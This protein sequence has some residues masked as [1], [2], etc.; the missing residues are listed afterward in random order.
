[1]ALTKIGSIGINTGIAF[2]GVTT[3]ATLNASDNVLSVG[4]TVNFVSDVS[5]GGTVSIAG[6]LTYEDVTNVDAVGL[7]TARDGIKV[8]S[9]ITLST[10]GDIFATGVTTATTFSGAFSGSGANITALNASN[11]ASGTVPSARLGSGTASSSTFLAGDSTFKTVSGTTINNNADNKVITGSGTANTLNAEG[12]VYIDAEGDLGLGISDITPTA[13]T[14]NGA[15]LQL[16]QGQS[17]SYG[18]QLKMTTASGGYAAGDG[19]YIAHWGGNNGTYIYNKENAALYFGTNA[20]ERFRIGDSSNGGNVTVTDGDLVF[21]SAGH[22][23]D[24]S[25]ASGSAAGSASALLDD[26]EEGTYDGT[27]SVT[28]GTLVMDTSHNQLSY[29]KIGRQVTITG[30]VQVS[31]V[32]GLSGYMTMNL[33]F[34]VGASSEYDHGGAGSIFMYNAGGVANAVLGRWVVWTDGGLSLIYFTYGD[35]QSSVLGAYVTAGTEVR[36]TFTYFAS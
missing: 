21:G 16:H 15:T 10:D 7:I 14:Y 19:F 2:A 28:S 30:R 6:T 35:G 22:G 1:M 8:G 33:P 20:A 27:L 32:S 26:Y 29:T 34:A 18:S 12:N 24:F 9:G 25:N 11:L 17:G 23:I 5:I 31:S 13:S 3:I 4:G 36:V